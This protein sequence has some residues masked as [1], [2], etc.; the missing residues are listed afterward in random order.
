MFSQFYL[1]FLLININGVIIIMLTPTFTNTYLNTYHSK[2]FEWKITKSFYTPH[3][4]NYQNHLYIHIY[5][6]IYN[7]IS[8][9]YALYKHGCKTFNSSIIYFFIFMPLV[10]VVLKHIYVLS[11]L[12]RKFQHFT[13]LT[14]RLWV[15]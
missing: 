8:Y 6:Y 14:R 15:V 4:S 11:F 5:K 3:V 1:F 9:T 2:N 10:F 7:Y 12:E 13:L